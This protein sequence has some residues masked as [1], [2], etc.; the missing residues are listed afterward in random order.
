MKKCRAKWLMVRNLTC[1]RRENLGWEIAS[2]RLACGNICGALSWL[3]IDRGE[4]RPN[5]ECYSYAEVPRMYRK[6]S[7]MWVL[8]QASNKHS[9]KVFDSA[10]AWVSSVTEKY[11]PK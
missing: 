10:S 7:W 11:K 8:E 5:G 4:P 3:E 6:G 9:P 2:I 1:K